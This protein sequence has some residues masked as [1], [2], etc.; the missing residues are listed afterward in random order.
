[1]NL[2]VSKYSMAEILATYTDKI[3]SKGGNKES[4]LTVEEVMEQ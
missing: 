4:G 2:D 3:L 1:M